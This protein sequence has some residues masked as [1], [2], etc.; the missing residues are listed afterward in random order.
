MTK[1]QYIYGRDSLSEQYGGNAYA[2]P[3]SDEKREEFYGI[4][5][6]RP[7]EAQSIYMCNPGQREGSLYLEKDFAYYRQPK[8]GRLEN[9][10]SDSEI[11]KFVD[12]GHQ[13]IIAWDTASQ[14]SHTAAWT[15]GI[16]GLLKPCTS[17]H[18]G[19]DPA[20]YGEC[21]FHFDLMI[22]DIFRQKID[23]G[24]LIHAVRTMHTK[25]HPLLHVIEQKQSGI[26]LL[27]T[28]ETVGIA[29]LGV[30]AQIS[31]YKRAVQSIGA[32]NSQGWFRMH[33]VLFPSE[34][35]DMGSDERRPISWLNAFKT[36]LKDFTGDEAGTT[37]QVDALIHLLH[38]T[39]NESNNA[40]MLPTD[41][42]IEMVDEQMGIHTDYDPDTGPSTPLQFLSWANDSL[43]MSEID[44]PFLDV[45]AKCKFYNANV[46]DQEFL[47]THCHKHKR[48][49]IAL[50]TCDDFMRHRGKN[51]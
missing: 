22:L 15:V 25:W 3:E 8:N 26:Q 51:G 5:L 21:D 32:S 31:K 20:I 7:D 39:I 30:N 18:R 42:T 17:Y 29:T 14:D 16:V 35:P 36:E 19:E 27:Q 24:D 23:F 33:R 45:C 12:H 11:R 13:T 28:M 37:D 2:W 38:Y 6:H 10:L 50:E 4:K 40:G 34:E 1:L 44:S 41:W 43:D 48:Q 47:G 49:F 9:G 46:K